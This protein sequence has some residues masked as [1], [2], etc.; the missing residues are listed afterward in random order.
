MMVI[1][2]EGMVAIIPQLTQQLESGTFFSIISERT[3]T[4]LNPDEMRVLVKTPKVIF[5]KTWEWQRWWQLF[6]YFD[7]FRLSV[8]EQMQS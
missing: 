1:V 8:G 6:I 3:A 4:L 2:L 7:D 5:E